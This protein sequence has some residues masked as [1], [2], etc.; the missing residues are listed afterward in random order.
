MGDRLRGRWQAVSCSISCAAEV[1]WDAL[2]S[3]GVLKVMTVRSPI[4][5]CM[6]AC[7]PGKKEKGKVCSIQTKN[8]SKMAVAGSLPKVAEIIPKVALNAPRLVQRP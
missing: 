6:Q 2:G 7:A 5:H 3:H 1:R 8:K 4:S